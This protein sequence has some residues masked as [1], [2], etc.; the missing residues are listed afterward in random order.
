MKNNQ[1]IPFNQKDL[2]LLNFRRDR[3]RRYWLGDLCCIKSSCVFQQAVIPYDKPVQEIFPQSN[4]IKWRNLSCFHCSTRK[5]IRPITGQALGV[6]C[7]STCDAAITSGQVVWLAGLATGYF[8]KC[9]ISPKG[10][11]TW[12]VGQAKEQVLPYRLYKRSRNSNTCESEAT[13][14]PT[15]SAR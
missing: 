4:F 12:D 13:A 9:S 6:G 14:T 8:Q 1:T 15:I 7:N 11:T 3:N 10:V 5:H 2:R